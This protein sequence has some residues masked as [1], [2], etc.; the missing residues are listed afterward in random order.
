MIDEKR[1]FNCPALIICEKLK[2]SE[3]GCRSG[4]TILSKPGHCST[5]IVLLLSQVLQRMNKHAHIP[6]A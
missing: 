5:S 4:S 3:K 2:T 6:E 1:E